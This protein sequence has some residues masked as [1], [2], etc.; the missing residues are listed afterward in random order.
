MTIHCILISIYLPNLIIKKVQSSNPPILPLFPSPPPKCKSVHPLFCMPFRPPLQ[1]HNPLES[2]RSATPIRYA[3]LIDQ[4]NSKH[5][6][7]G[8]GLKTSPSLIKQNRKPGRKRERKKQQ[9]L[10]RKIGNAWYIIT[11]LHPLKNECEDNDG[12]EL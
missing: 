1:N 2:L 7:K 3:N 9:R 8:T 4:I 5:P 6:K 10:G 11:P 12:V